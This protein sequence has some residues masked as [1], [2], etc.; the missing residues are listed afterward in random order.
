MVLTEESLERSIGSVAE[1]HT[2]QL[3][4][5]QLQL[6]AEAKARHNVE[7]ATQ[8]LADDMEELMKSTQEQVGQVERAIQRL[9]L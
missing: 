8:G 3:N 9:E 5:V 4:E 7:V 1:T 2:G 6:R